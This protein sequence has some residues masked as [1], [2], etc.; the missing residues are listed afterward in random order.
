MVSELGS[1]KM[2]V[3]FRG[4]L[5]R[6][7]KKRA[8][9]LQLAVEPPMAVRTEEEDIAVDVADMVGEVGGVEQEHLPSR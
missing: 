6:H 3:L 4:S 9:G 8:R 7:A 5:S 2:V 1:R